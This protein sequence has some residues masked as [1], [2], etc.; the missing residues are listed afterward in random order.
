MVSHDVQFKSF[1]MSCLTWSRSLDHGVPEFFDV[2]FCP[3]Q[4]LDQDAIF[5]AISKKHV[6]V[7]HVP[8]NLLSQT[9]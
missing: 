7:T 4:P 3:Y 1:A 5:A 9:N 2:K 6:S 8:N